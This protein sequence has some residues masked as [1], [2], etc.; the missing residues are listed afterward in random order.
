MKRFQ[1]V[2]YVFLLVVFCIGPVS[3]VYASDVEVKT[4]PKVALVLS[5]GG[6][7]GFAHVGVIKVLEEIGV[8]VDMVVGT[9]MGSMVGGSYASGYT[10]K[11]MED[12]ILNVNWNE[13]FALR[14][15]RDELDWRQRDDD[16]K[17]LFPRVIGITPEGPKTS[18]ALVPSQ[19]LGVF[20]SRITEHVANVNNLDRLA[21]PY[22]AIATDLS[23]GSMVVLQKKVSLATAMRAS[24]SV[25]G[26][27][28]PLKYQGRS[29]V[30]GGLVQNLPVEQAKAMG[31]D[32]VIAINVGTPLS[33]PEQFNS[34][35]SVMAQMVGFLTERN[36]DRSKAAL[37]AN[38]ILIT[39][40]LGEYSAADFE[41]A[42]DI[43]DA[44]EKSARQYI[45]RL[46]HLAVKKE[47]FERWNLARNRAVH[48]PAPQQI[49]D[50]RVEGLKTVNPEVV[51]KHAGLEKGQWLTQEAMEKASSRIWASDDFTT[52][53][54]EIEPGPDG[55]QV[56][57]FRPQEN[58]WG[59]NTVRI[60]G[61]IFTDFQ[62]DHSFQVVVNH[63]M[64]WLNAWGGE[65]RNDL[66]VGK[67]GY[68][69]TSIY[70]PLGAGSPFFVQPEV[71]YENHNYEIYQ[72]R[73]YPDSHIR[74]RLFEVQ[75]ALGMELG[76]YGLIRAGLGYAD[77][78]ARSTEGVLLFDGEKK[79]QTAYARASLEMD[80]LDNVAFP[81][82]GFS[83]EAKATHFQESLI[84][85]ENATD[86]LFEANVPI[87]W[88]N[89][90]VTYLTMK[91]GE[92]SI[93]GRFALGGLFNLSGT[94]YARYAG[95]EMFLGR[96][97]AYKR[98]PT[99]GYFGFPIY[100]GTSFEMGKFEEKSGQNFT[101]RSKDIG[102][103][104]K[105]GSVFVAANSILGPVY[106]G[107][108]RTNKDDTSVYFYWGVPY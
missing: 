13:I 61:K 71:S 37:G 97:I 35:V 26:A 67:D 46:K 107:V 105:A 39:P 92:S 36:V 17:N 34:V 7:R 56:V 76:N 21:I 81:K 106:L 62:D 95:S 32:V 24:M 102:Q 44:G 57:V 90:F 33:K 98:L 72:G 69:S 52:V 23:D 79:T 54:Y 16:Y 70:Q 50:V 2:I 4:R 89:D 68:L 11:Q 38:D 9:S 84:S 48:T 74:N 64:A 27:F 77:M 85:G 10:T 83:L 82:T 101:Y 80:T 31:A 43:I 41:S 45:D 99:K 42:R 3:G 8:P 14:P 28:A 108:G 15:N 55:T 40:D 78:A 12:I 22:A 6:A 86:Y 60:G 18:S 25:P 87:H 1:S 103:W 91:A 58:P 63:T 65:W 100:V 47:V 94:S 5:G 75:A 49:A 66:R 51:K 104:V 96:V 53:P 73:D 30:D 20:L 19:N 88:G 59:Y 93:P 29:L